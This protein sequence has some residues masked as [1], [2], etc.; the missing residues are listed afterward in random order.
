MLRQDIQQV[1]NPPKFHHQASKKK[2]QKSIYLQFR[3]LKNE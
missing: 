1:S 2:K 3:G